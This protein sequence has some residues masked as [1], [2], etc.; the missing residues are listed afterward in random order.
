MNNE[1]AKLSLNSDMG[2][3]SNSIRI[4]FVMH[5][6]YIRGFKYSGIRFNFQFAG[7]K[8]G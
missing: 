8:S 6:I 7:I 4:Q 3:V 5:C 2:Q 1:F